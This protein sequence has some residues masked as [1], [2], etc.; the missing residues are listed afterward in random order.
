M[1]DHIYA[2]QIYSK[3][4]Y[5]AHL[6][7]LPLSLVL[8]PMAVLRGLLSPVLFSAKTLNSYSVASMRPPMVNCLSFERS[9]LHFFQAL[10]PA[11]LNSIQYPRISLPPSDSGRSQ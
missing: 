7:N 11:C 9:L 3:V 5:M 10:S 1:Y 2:L 6:S 8:M 4:I